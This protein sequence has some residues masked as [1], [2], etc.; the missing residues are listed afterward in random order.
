M[1]KTDEKNKGSE[2]RFNLGAGGELSSYVRSIFDAFKIARR[3]W[4]DIWEESWLNFMGQYQENLKWKKTEGIPNR[5]RVFVKL[6]TLKC[7]TAHSKIM[8]VHNGQVPF[9]IE[10][11][12]IEEL[13]LDP[14]QIK[15]IIKKRKDMLEGHLKYIEFEEIKD[16]AILELC[17]LGTAVIKGPIIETRKKTVARPRMIAGMKATDVD[18]EV[19]SHEITTEEETLAVFDHIPLWE[20]YCDMNAKSPDQ[21]IGEIQFKRILPAQFA[22]LAY[23]GGYDKKAVMEAMRHA[24]STDPDDERYRQLGDNYAGQQGEKDVRVSVLEYQGL[25]PVGYLRSVNCPDIPED[26]EDDESIEAI[27]VLAGWGIPIKYCINPLG[28]RQFKVCPY[29]KR[30]NIIPGMGVAES[31]RDSQ[32]MINSATRLFIDNKALSGN[33][34]VGI[35]LDRI[36]TKRTKDLKVYSGKT[37]YV[38]GNFSPREA[39]ESIIFPDISMGLREIIELFERF[40]DEETGL[41]KYTT[42]TQNNFLNK[43]ASGMSMLM[44]QANIS[45]KTTMQNIDNYWIEPIVEALDAWF[46]EY[47][48]PEELKIPIKVK[49]R[50]TDSLMA[51]EIKIENIM[52]WLQI[53]AAPQDAILADRVKAMKDIARLMD[54]DDYVKPQEEIDKVMQE[55]TR[56]ANS[57]KDTREMVDLDRLYPLLTRK[58]QV[59]I[60]QQLGIQPDMGPDAEN[61]QMGMQEGMQD[62]QQAQGG[63]GG[64]M[65]DEMMQG[66]GDMGGMNEAP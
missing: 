16:T 63:P 18:P 9:D 44:T 43:T 24:T 23:Q 47:V 62:P 53:T 37:W 11:V 48:Y 19:S 45:M 33:G 1:E 15:D 50:G 3:P 49:A 32:K 25:V 14:E 60:L 52:K 5:S 51:K 27:V 41:P 22:Q 36:N 40:S 21:G 29:K 12:N 65:P 39:I 55:M 17:I 20:Y 28:Q 35:N 30:P 59:Q 38:K 66:Q 64:P 2:E 61:M 10:A 4:E 7:H 13:G 54:T 57:P 8:D 42:G 56:Q 58:E 26:M 6:T 34:M 46:F 31:M